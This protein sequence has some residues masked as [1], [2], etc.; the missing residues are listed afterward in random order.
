MWSSVC[1]IMTIDRTGAKRVEFRLLIQ[2]T[3]GAAREGRVGMER[4]SRQRPIFN[5]DVRQL[6]NSLDSGFSSFT[7]C[8]NRLRSCL[9]QTAVTVLLYHSATPVDSRMCSVYHKYKH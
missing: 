7:G 2:S 8:D 5:C 1:P 3:D 6:G 9:V 4:V